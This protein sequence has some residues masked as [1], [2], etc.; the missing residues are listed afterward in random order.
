MKLAGVTLLYYPDVHFF[1]RLNSYKAHLDKLIIINN[2]ELADHTLSEKLQSNYNI[3]ILHDGENKGIARRLN[4]AAELAL[5]AGFEWLLTM[6]QDSFF[7]ERIFEQYLECIKSYEKKQNVALF[8]VEFDKRLITQKECSYKKVNY[9]I[10]SGNI[11][12]LRVWEQTKGYNESFFIDHVDHDYCFQCVLKGYDIIKF[13]SILLQHSLGT[14]AKYHSVKNY[15]R[16]SRYLHSPLR[17]YYM[18][19]NYLY[20]FD[21]FSEKFPEDLKKIKKS[22]LISI[23]NNLIY[24]NKRLSVI[25]YLMKALVDF[26][27]KRYGKVW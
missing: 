12:N 21:K 3:S 6:D 25:N 24:N 16:S 4:E 7:S 2:S 8:A 13:D 26:K 18:V 1:D 15:K 9:V 20:L 11:I 22:V 17:I 23:K 14:V 10:T 5:K 19:R 27:I